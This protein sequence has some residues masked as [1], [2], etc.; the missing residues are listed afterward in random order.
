MIRRPPRSTRTDTLFPYTTLFR[1]TAVRLLATAGQGSGR[2]ARP[3]NQ[4]F[5]TFHAVFSS[6]AA[7][8]RH[9]PSTKHYTSV[10]RGQAADRSDRL[11]LKTECGVSIW[12]ALS[13]GRW[14]FGPGVCGGSRGARL[15]ERRVGK[16]CG[17]TVKARW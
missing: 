12:L 10:K 13:A 3:C 5:A 7:D 2:Q 16:E 6:V 11:R 15:V 14:V 17:S 4:Y 1:S 8:G 9:E